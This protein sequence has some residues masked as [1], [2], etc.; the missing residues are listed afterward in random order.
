[1]DTEKAILSAIYG[2]LESD[3]ELD[4]ICSG[5]RLG[6]IWAPKDETFPYLVHRLTAYA[7]YPGVVQRADYFLD[8]WDYGDSATK[9]Y[10]MRERAVALLDKACII[11]DGEGYAV[12]QSDEEMSGELLLARLWLASFGLIPED[13]DK[14]WHYS[15]TFSMRFTRS[16]TEITNLT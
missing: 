15:M 10:S 7:D 4:T 2:H 14:I 6:L 3:S 5:V 1:M 9:I 11:Q 8:L 13:V 16:L 12:V